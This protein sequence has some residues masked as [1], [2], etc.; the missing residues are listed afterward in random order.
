MIMTSSF[1]R[2]KLL[3]MSSQFDRKRE[4]LKGVRFC[5]FA[6]QCVRIFYMFIQ[7]VSRI[8]F[9]NTNLKHPRER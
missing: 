2:P 9:Q 8:L 6:V 3:I 5:N 4:E 1:L 7:V